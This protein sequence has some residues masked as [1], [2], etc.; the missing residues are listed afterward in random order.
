MVGRDGFQSTL[1]LR[2]ATNSDST[3]ASTAVISIHAL[4]AESDPVGVR[5]P[6]LAGN[7]N[8]RSPCGE[9][10]LAHVPTLLMIWISIHALLAESDEDGSTVDASGDHFN[11]RSPCGERPQCLEDA[12]KVE[13]I[14]IHALLAESD[15][16]RPPGGGPGDQ[17]QST[18]SLRRATDCGQA[19]TPAMGFQST[20]S[21]RR[22]TGRRG[23]SH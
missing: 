10:L 1:S 2:R 16:T 17:F 3:P 21:L 15:Y 8:P 5:L 19:I 20:L 13:C 22:A 11:P 12:R 23:G 7:F 9:R 6:D 4:L 18:L 14:S